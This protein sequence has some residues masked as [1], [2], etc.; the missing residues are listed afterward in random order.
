[1]FP[2]LLNQCQM[3]GTKHLFNTWYDF[4]FTSNKFPKEFSGRNSLFFLS[5]DLEEIYIYTHT[6]VFLIAH[7]KKHFFFLLFL[8]EG[9]KNVFSWQ[10]WAK[11]HNYIA[12]T[13]LSFVNKYAKESN[14]LGFCPCQWIV[15]P[16]L[17][18]LSW[19]ATRADRQLCFN[20]SP[21]SH[22]R[23]SY[24]VFFSSD[25][26][27]VMRTMDSVGSLAVLLTLVCQSKRMCEVRKPELL[28]I[29]LV[30]DLSRD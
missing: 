25:I 27:F 29:F 23:S 10:T 30:S 8:H 6:Y 12:N 18:W 13:N 20:T 22:N 11:E 28:T 7:P 19:L 3:A 2:M 5:H 16:L 1:M 4:V 14:A 26:I 24:G 9:K 21:P 15:G 17:N